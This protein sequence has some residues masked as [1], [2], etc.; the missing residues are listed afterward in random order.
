MQWIKKREKSNNKQQKPP[1][2][3]GIRGTGPTPPAGLTPLVIDRRDS[4]EG[5]DSPSAGVGAFLFSPRRRK[6]RQSVLSPQTPGS[7]GTMFSHE[8][9]SAGGVLPQGITR[10]DLAMAT[11]ARDE[12]DFV[13]E[14]F[15]ACI[16]ACG[17]PGAED[18]KVKSFTG[19]HRLLE[20]YVLV[21]HYMSPGGVTASM[22]SGVIAE[23]K[24]VD[25]AR[26][27]LAAAENLDMV[28]PLTP[29]ELINP[30]A[31]EQ[32]LLI[33]AALF[34]RFSDPHL[35]FSCGMRPLQPP[36][37]VKAKTPLWPEGSEITTA[38][39]W[40][41]RMHEAWSRSLRWRGAGA[42]AQS[43]A[44][45]ALLSKVQGREGPETPGDIAV[46]QWYVDDPLAAWVVDSSGGSPVEKLREF[47]LFHNILAEHYPMIRR[48]YL[49]Y[50]TGDH[51][52]VELSVDE[53]FKMFQ[54]AKMVGGKMFS[55]SRQ[56]CEDIF[57]KVLDGTGKSTL[58]P[59]DFVLVLLRL[60][61]VK[62]SW[63]SL[64]QASCV[65]RFRSLLEEYLLANA[66]YLGLDEF[67]RIIYSDKCAEVLDR[68]RDLV[69]ATFR[70]YATQGSL[71]NRL[72]TLKDFTEV[73]GMMNVV[74]ASFSHEQVRSIF[75]K[76]QNMDDGMGAG[77]HTVLVAGVREH[78]LSY[79]QFLEC[80]SMVAMFKSPLPYLPTC[81]RLS[82]FFDGSF[83]PTFNDSKLWKVKGE[84]QRIKQ[85]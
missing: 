39:E 33:A 37:G 78:V 79:R 2:V 10:E 13:L 26:M 72:M 12:G 76:V 84:L 57:R 31:R 67:R 14:W 43:L 19:G 42:A 80:V 60:A 8:E 28:F 22:V 15:N 34:Q 56:H 36:V 21:M 59:K 49:F 66:N 30:Q 25:K 6:R 53:L 50:S 74:D 58:H 9:M 11:A 24:D 75:A 18:Y 41:K 27:V 40:R 5:I 61:E 44:T 81:R 48:V 85:R 51:L 82:R 52:D 70:A 69:L 54:D 55:V 63:I 47:G 83:V 73:V 23:A 77:G 46:R 1:H 64:K 65:S 32:H 17:Y 71:S 68:N 29:Y 16:N 38:R 7:P 45:E 20:P 4:V 3:G 62:K 35:A